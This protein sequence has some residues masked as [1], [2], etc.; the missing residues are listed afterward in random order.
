MAT[1]IAQEL[2]IVQT[3]EPLCVVKH[4]RFVRRVRVVVDI[5]REHLLDACDVVVDLVF[6]QQ[7]A[8][9]RT[10]RRV[11]HLCRAA[12]HQG[13]RLVASLLQPTQHHD[14]DQRS[15]VQ[16]LR[17]CVKA[18]VGR[19]HALAQCLIEALII[20]AVRKEAALHHD[21]HEIGFGMVGHRL[22]LG[23]R[24]RH[25]ISGSTGE[26]KRMLKSGAI[27][28]LGAMSGTSLDGV[29]AAVLVTDGVTITEFGPSD[30]RPYSKEESSVLRAALGKWDGAEVEAA[31]EVIETAHAQI[32]SGFEDV[33]LIGFHGQTVAHDPAN[34]GTLQIG[35]GALLAEVLERPVV[36]DFRSNDVKLG[37]QGAPLAPFYHFALAKFIGATAPVAFLNLGGV[38]NITWVDPTLCVPSHSLKPF[39]KKTIL[40]PICITEFISWVLM[41][42][43]I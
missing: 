12:T 8:F 42:V 4:Q 36:W 13:D 3:V 1:D 5:G 30:F 22:V 7:R 20:R 27:R 25:S 41:I 37:G 19:Y 21:S 43:V 39:F 26:G 33:D 11:A 6:G 24:S 40:S 9:V 28:A 18:D 14:L 16:R 31:A 10:E 32:L 35:D 34:R 2:E 29:D 15:N 17:S 38:G 23:F